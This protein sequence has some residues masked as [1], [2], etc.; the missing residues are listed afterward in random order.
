[1]TLTL[2]CRFHSH[3]LGGRPCLV[4]LHPDG[5][6]L[7][8][9]SGTE[10]GQGLFTKAK[11]VGTFSFCLGS[12]VAPLFRCFSAALLHCCL[13]AGLGSAGSQLL[14]MFC[15]K[16]P[17]SCASCA[18]IRVPHAMLLTL[19]LYHPPKLTRLTQGTLCCH[20][21]FQC[22]L[23]LGGAKMQYIP[24][25]AMQCSASGKQ[26]LSKTLFTWVDRRYGTFD[27]NNAFGSNTNCMQR[28]HP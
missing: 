6:V 15:G 20:A 9:C 10:M 18:S 19:L 28:Q 13:W 17:S 11:Q 1:M 21:R 7:V 25:A 14:R 12:A 24:V 26:C 8:T 27:S 4:H 5:S 16:L 2:Y 3:C 23:G 22:L